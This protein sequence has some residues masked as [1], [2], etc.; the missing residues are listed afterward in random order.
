[1]AV[2]RWRKL[3]A[4]A[5]RTSPWPTG[6]PP[7]PGPLCPHQHH[8]HPAPHGAHPGLPW[9]ERKMRKTKMSL[10]RQKPL[11]SGWVSLIMEVRGAEGRD[12]GGSPLGKLPPRQ[13]FLKGWD[14][15]V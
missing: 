4:T 15:F 6:L 3:P 11:E 9:P 8:S 2:E 5:S 13:V 7:L 12:G 1:M 10:Q 14:L